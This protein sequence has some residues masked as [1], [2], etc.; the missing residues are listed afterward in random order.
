MKVILGKA[1]TGK[2]QYIYEK[3]YEDVKNKKR[4]FLFVPSQTRVMAEENY[5]H[6]LQLEGIIGVNITTM[7]EF[8]S[9]VL[10]KKNLHF[11][12]YYLSKLDKKMIMTQVLQENPDLFHI[13][14]KVK[15]KEGFF[16]ILNIYMDI[17]RKENIDVEKVDTLRLKDKSLEKKLKEI[18]KV[19]E[20]YEEKIT[21]KYMD[22]MDEIDLLTKNEELVKEA[23]K[24]AKIYFDGYNNFTK[25]ELKLIQLF[26]LLG[27]DVT[28]TL[29]TDIEGIEDIENGDTKEIFEMANETYM[30][31]VH[32]AKATNTPFLQ[33]V[34]YVNFS[35]SNSDIIFLYE[36]LFSNK[37][38]SLTQKVTQEKRKFDAISLNVY[39]N[40]YKEAESIAYQICKKRKENSHYHDFCIYTTD[41]ENY[42]SIFARVFYEYRI[43]FYVDTKMAIADTKLVQYLLYLLDIGT[44]GIQMESILRILKLGFNHISELDVAYFENYVTEF[45]IQKYGLKKAFYLNHDRYHEQRYDLEKLNQIRVKVLEIFEEITSV[46]K[47]K[48]SAKQIITLICE[49]FI[50]ENI[51]EKYHQYFDRIE[52]KSYLTYHIRMK[53]QVWEKICEI[54]DSIEKVYQE[55]KMTL[56]QFQQIFRYAIKDIYL[57]TIPPTKD[58]VVLAD[59]NVTKMNMTKY[60]FFVGVIEG[61]FPKKAD[62]DIFFNDYELEILQMA[63]T[64]FKET[65]IS[66]EN[67]GLFNIYD[68]LGNVEEELYISMPAI[69]LS[70]NSTRKSSFFMLVQNLTGLKLLGNVSQENGL[71]MNYDDIFS[72]E[73]QFEYFVQKLREV[74]KE[75]NQLK[76]LDSNKIKEILGM[77]EYF[78]M[79]P[80]Y[81]S[82]L[83]YT[84][85]DDNLSQDTMDMLYHETLK[86]SVYKLELFKSCPFSYYMKYVLNLSKKKVFDITNM[87]MGSFMHDI[88]EKFSMYLFEHDIFWHEI[89]ENDNKLQEKYEEVLNEIIQRQLNENFKKQQESVKYTIYKQKL[90]HTLKKVMIVIARGFNQSEFVPY[91]YELEFKDG[92]D[93]L[94]IE[95]ELQQGKIMKIVGKIDRIDVLETPENIYAR[96]VD[97]KSSAKTLTVDQIKEG[98]SL[99]LITYLTAFV[100]SKNKLNE[101]L[102]IKKIGSHSSDSDSK[103][104]EILPSASL[105]LN[106]SDKLL[107]LKDYTS[108]EEVIQKEIMKKLR[109]NGI[110]LS[111]VKILEK[112]DKKV[113]K[114]D[115]KLIDVTPN[116]KSKKMLEQEEF[117]QLCL[118][119]KEILRKIGNEMLSG[120]VKI[121][122]NKK[123]KPCEYCDFAS[124]C[125]KNICL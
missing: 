1:K 8:V 28:I 57:K 25:A 11:D 90:V 22:Q 72:K 37:A 68:A 105:Y 44:N 65:S 75:L 80:F 115:E 24:G 103:K 69:D 40:A 21:G 62:Q 46:A 100:E 74:E 117:N 9:S 52:D 101:I 92:G 116:R 95:I 34:M 85:N 27:L 18:V 43:P 35:K 88:L 119:T 7:Q 120:K 51:F 66:K 71:E 45:S 29:K 91:G 54:F 97:Y 36:N 23:L 17:F 32:L 55:Q 87:D 89:L 113:S 111:D 56:N 94:P 58:K 67:M 49:H 112:M 42:A 118:D 122:P 39:Q 13:F 102:K 125:R 47:E 38:K 31:L 99:Q 109:M 33:K 30:R 20:K 86:S 19:Y 84:K 41:L 70:S 77:Y 50:K 2:S 26:L 121:L 73:K 64:K 108:E 48:K 16:D 53:E 98:I 63:D 4:P 114:A 76:T 107:N 123:V 110:F 61:S 104:K 12:E 5:I 83:N 14:K 96:V 106:L 3:I 6:Y 15:Y 10:K 78:V 124:V 59:I 60:V 79:D 82:I 81:Q 93:L